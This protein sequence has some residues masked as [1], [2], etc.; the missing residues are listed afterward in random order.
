MSSWGSHFQGEVCVWSKAWRIVGTSLVSDGPHR[1][2]PNFRRSLGVRR[3]KGIVPRGGRCRPYLDPQNSYRTHGNSWSTTVK[4]RYSKM[5]PLLH[6]YTDTSPIFRIL[7]KFL[8]GPY[9]ITILIYTIL[10]HTT[11]YYPTLFYTL[12]SYPI[13]SYIYYPI[14]YLMLY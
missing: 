9:I 6:S 1:Q 5:T 14:L 2:D 10:C 8:W 13:L 7:F 4:Q 3:S 11:L 12:L